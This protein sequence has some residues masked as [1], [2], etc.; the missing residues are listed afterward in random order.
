M[1]TDPS[2]AVQHHASRQRGAYASLP[3]CGPPASESALTW[4]LCHD[5]DDRVVVLIVDVDPTGTTVQDPT[6]EPVAPADTSR[7]FHA[8]LGAVEAV[9]EDEGVVRLAPSP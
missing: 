1:L 3:V 4:Q 5:D 7:M 8:L 2:P 6:R 9:D